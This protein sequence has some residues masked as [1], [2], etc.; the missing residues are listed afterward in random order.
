M[1]KLCD[2]GPYRFTAGFAPRHVDEHSK[3]DDWFK[4]DTQAKA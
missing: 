3:N 4:A 2:E 1:C